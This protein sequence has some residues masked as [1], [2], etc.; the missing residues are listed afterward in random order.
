MNKRILFGTA[1]L[2]GLASTTTQA[3]DKTILVFDASGS[4]W[5]QIKANPKSKL[6]A[7][8]LNRCLLN[9]QQAK[10]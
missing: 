1:M 3:A 9:G 4:M 6:P 8:L 2:L 5:E 7:Q 10:K